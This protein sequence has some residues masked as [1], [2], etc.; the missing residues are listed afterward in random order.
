VIY[1]TVG[2]GKKFGI[3]M[4][5]ALTMTE[6]IYFT[7]FEM[8]R[9]KFLR[10]LILILALVAIHATVK[11][12]SDKIY[13][14]NGELYAGE[15]VAIGSQYIL[16]RYDEQVRAVERSAI[17][18]VL[19]GGGDFVYSETITNHTTTQSHTPLPSPRFR[20]LDRNY[21]IELG[22][23][24]YTLSNYALNMH[25]THWFRNTHKWSYGGQ[26]SLDFS[27]YVMFKMSLLVKRSF[28][29]A[30]SERRKSYLVAA[31][32][33]APWASYA[34]AQDR[35]NVEWAEF[36]TVYQGALGAGIWME[37]GSNSA[38]TFEGGIA[39]TTF[40]VEEHLWS[41]DGIQRIQRIEALN[42]GPYFRMGLAF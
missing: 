4:I 34:F 40:K 2:V 24:L 26:M 7:T 28:S 23:G 18:F 27:K 38:L 17:R 3:E 20:T 41:W 30:D 21:V 31:G 37:T 35:W 25:M 6:L 15:I 22:G 5:S 8:K 42:L 36:S 19:K 39:L 10:Y 33:L 12:Q 1:Q 16:I 14:L 29:V 13:M 32:S 11:A 9:M